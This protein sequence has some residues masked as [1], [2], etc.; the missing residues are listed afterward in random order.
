[1]RS[2][3]AWRGGQKTTLARRARI[4]LLAA[5]GL[6]NRMISERLELGPPAVGIGA[7]FAER[8]LDGLFSES[9]AGGA[10]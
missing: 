1:M 2:W 3:S 6:T 10:S 5:D 7:R 9:R 8:G 4:V